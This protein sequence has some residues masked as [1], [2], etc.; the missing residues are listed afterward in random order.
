MLLVSQLIEGTSKLLKPLEKFLKKIINKQG[1]SRTSCLF[2]D[3]LNKMK[4]YW[5][6]EICVLIDRH[7]QERAIRSIQTNRQ[8]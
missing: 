1:E 8:N 7:S 6:S 5:Q 3:Y 4:R 2:Y